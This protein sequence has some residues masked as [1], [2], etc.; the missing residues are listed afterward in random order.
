MILR[1]KMYDISQVLKHFRPK[2]KDGQ[3]RHDL[4][5]HFR[6]GEDPNG[7]VRMSLWEKRPGHRYS[8][9]RWH[10]G[11]RYEWP[12]V[13]ER[14][15]A[16]RNFPSPDGVPHFCEYLMLPLIFNGPPRIAWRLTFD[17]EPPNKRTSL[18]EWLFDHVWATS[19]SF[20]E[21]SEFRGPKV[22]SDASVQLYTEYGGKWAAVATCPEAGKCNIQ[23]EPIP[24][25]SSIT[26]TPLCA[27]F[28]VLES[29]VFSAILSYSLLKN[30][31]LS[32]SLAYHVK[33]PRSYA[34]TCSGSGLLPVVMPPEGLHLVS[35]SAIFLLIWPWM[36]R[37]ATL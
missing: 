5:I 25:N 20:S 12:C 19:H 35:V 8:P 29:I 36:T 9:R 27:V 16:L 7:R 15:D 13:T 31:F 17:I 22:L 33:K 18:M 32:T 21:R 10:H 37:F 2:P 11:Y 26:M 14:R 30:H 6:R 3:V 24:D 34:R 23:A 4:S 1:A 28:V